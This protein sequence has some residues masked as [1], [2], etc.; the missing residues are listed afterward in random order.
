MKKII[1]FSLVLAMSLATISCKKEAKEAKKS[2]SAQF[3]IEPKTVVI[4]WIGYKTTSKIPVKGEFKEVTISNIKE[5]PTAVEAMNGS[6][7]SIPV[8]S[9]FSDLEDRD[10]KLKELFFGVMDATINLTGTV[11]LNDDGTGNVNLK[12]NGV[13][14]EIPVTYTVSDQIVQFEGTLDIVDD[15]NAQSAL[16]SLSKACFDLHKG[17]DLVSKTWSEVTISARAHLKKK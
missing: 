14:K 9:L 5:A 17:P 2:D 11:N 3:S 15:F 7:F 10:T 1:L 13:S 8:S 12:M 16:E 4:N 6:Q